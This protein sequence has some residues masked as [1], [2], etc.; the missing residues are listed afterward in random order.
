MHMDYK[1]SPGHT[2]K[3]I[4]AIFCIV[5]IFSKGVT[6]SQQIT[7]SH[8]I[9]QKA[10]ELQ[11]IIRSNRLQG[12]DV[13][14]AVELDRRSM[15]AFERGRYDDALKLIEEAIS[16]MNGTVGFACVFNDRIFL[17]GPA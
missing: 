10:R 6:L 15:N 1:K 8:F 2:C 14:K 9:V 4:T 13:S 5:C 17:L 12:R 3:L 7:D 16:I 11:E